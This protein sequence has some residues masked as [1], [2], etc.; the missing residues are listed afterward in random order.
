MSGRRSATDDHDQQEAVGVGYFAHLASARHLLL[1]TFERDGP[2]VSAPVPGWLTGIEPT[3]L[4]G[5]GRVA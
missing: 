5:A 3:S 2:P 4:R 1:T